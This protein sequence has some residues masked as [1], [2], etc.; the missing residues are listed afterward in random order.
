MNKILVKQ[1]T[2]RQDFSVRKRRMSMI[3]LRLSSAT[4]LYETHDTITR[5]VLAVLK[6]HAQH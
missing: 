2:K 1:D 3:I 4:K 5:Q 6:E